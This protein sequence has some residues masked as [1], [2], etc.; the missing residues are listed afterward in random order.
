M[1]GHAVEEGRTV[2]LYSAQTL[3]NG[4]TS[5]YSC[6]LHWTWHGQVTKSETPEDVGVV[7]PGGACKR[8][9]SVF[10]LLPG[11]CHFLEN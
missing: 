1:A 3:G 2:N 9:H 8:R 6:I 5:R 11:A 10:F 7:A 4:I